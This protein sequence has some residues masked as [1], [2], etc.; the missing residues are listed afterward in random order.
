LAVFF[1]LARL[2][3]SLAA[4]WFA[5]V[6]LFFYGWWNPRY[7]PLLLASIVFNYGMG[8]AIGRFQGRFRA[9]ALLI[10]ALAVNLSLLAVFKYTDFAIDS[11]NA[12]LDLGIPHADLILP[13][14]ISFFTFTQISFLVDVY[15]GKAREH[16][17]IHYTLFVTFFPH[18]IAG[19]VLHHS[20]MMPQFALP[21]TY[22]LSS[23]NIAIGLSMFTIGL[24]KKVLLADTFGGYA[25]PVFSATHDGITPGFFVFWLGALV[26]AL[27]RFFRV[28]RHGHRSVSIVRD[29]L[30]DQLQL[31]I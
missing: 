5:A 24:A 1:L 12:V 25:G 4:T 18:L 10:A 3:G 20:Q 8:Y 23:A 7:V 14:G 13:L 30:S 15:L 9:K 31:T 6:S 2:G 21:A 17:F 16:N 19:P 27:L 28:L 29:R 22:R 26:T 11:V